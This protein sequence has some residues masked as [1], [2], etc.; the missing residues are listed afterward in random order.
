VVISLEPGARRQ[1]KKKSERTIVPDCICT[2]TERKIQKHASVHIQQQHLYITERDARRTIR[3]A[4]CVVRR[5]E[6]EAERRRQ[7]RKRARD[8]KENEVEP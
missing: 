5:P 4:L 2:Y 3:R 7:K 1:R 8:K 6:S